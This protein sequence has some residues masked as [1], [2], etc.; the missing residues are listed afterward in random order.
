MAGDLGDG[1]YL[2]GRDR[3]SRADLTVTS[4]FVQP[5]F[6][7]A[8]PEVLAMIE[9]RPTIRPYLQRVCNTVG[10]EIPRWLR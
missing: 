4:L 5:G 10:G 3:P 2:L 1:P 7:D 6:G 9:A 8:M